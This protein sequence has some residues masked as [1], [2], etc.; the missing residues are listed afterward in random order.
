MIREKLELELAE[1]GGHGDVVGVLR[2]S[3]EGRKA[4]GKGG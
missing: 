3:Q 1:K 4:R 2:S